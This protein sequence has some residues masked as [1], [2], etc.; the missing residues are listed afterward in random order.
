DRSLRVVRQ[1]HSHIAHHAPTPVFVDDVDLATRV[2]RGAD[3][4]FGLL[5]ELL[6]RWIDE[7][8][9]LSVVAA[10]VQVDLSIGAIDWPTETEQLARAPGGAIL[11]QT[12]LPGRPIVPNRRVVLRDSGEGNVLHRAARGGRRRRRRRRRWSGLRSRGFR[13]R[14]R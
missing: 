13:L 10:L 14:A 7:R 1:Q 6:G 12:R 5:G 8:P 2:L 3:N 9:G 11:D 4:A